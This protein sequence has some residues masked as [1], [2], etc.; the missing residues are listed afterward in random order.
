M[1]KRNSTKNCRSI[2]QLGEI[3]KMIREKGACDPNK[4]EKMEKLVAFIQSL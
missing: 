3:V 4:P 1:T 2:D